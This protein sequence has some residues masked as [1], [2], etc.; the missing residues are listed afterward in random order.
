MA[1]FTP[2]GTFLWSNCCNL[3]SHCNEA[4]IVGPW[5]LEWTDSSLCIPKKISSSMAL[6]T[7]DVETLSLPKQSLSVLA[8][9]LAQVVTTWNI[10]YHYTNFNL[11][12]K[13]PTE[14]N[15]QDFVNAVL[16]KL[17]VT[18]TFRGA[19]GTQNCSNGRM[20]YTKYL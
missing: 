18:P 1:C 4:L 7:L 14:G 5:Y 16:D 8:D 10:N 20:F 15:C 13:K 2:V 12:P 17:E 11:G 6:L 19:L 9:R 3:I